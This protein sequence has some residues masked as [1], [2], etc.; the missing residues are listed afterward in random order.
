M[1]GHLPIR[2]T[3]AHSN[4]VKKFREKYDILRMLFYHKY[5][6]ESLDGYFQRLPS[7]KY[8]MDDEHGKKDRYIFSY[9]P[10]HGEFILEFHFD[11]DWNCNELYKVL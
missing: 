8:N 5:R 10:K 7:S 9:T 1:A 11:Q 2:Q 3:I 4:I 6:V